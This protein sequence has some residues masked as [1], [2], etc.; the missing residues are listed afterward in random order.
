MAFAAV[1]ASERLADTTVEE[2]RHMLK[3]FGP[4]NAF[5]ILAR[6]FREFVNP[7]RHSEGGTSLSPTGFQ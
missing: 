1:S 5:G 6:D 7:W 4:R 2:R 3:G